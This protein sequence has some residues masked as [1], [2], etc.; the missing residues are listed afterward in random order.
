MKTIV[1]HCGECPLKIQA[2]DMGA[3]FYFCGIRN[4]ETLCM[5][6]T[7]V[8]NKTVNKDC[9]LKTEPLTIELKF[10]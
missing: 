9:P 4:S 6:N 3:T 5:I 8:A 2:K 7:D 1:K 10:E